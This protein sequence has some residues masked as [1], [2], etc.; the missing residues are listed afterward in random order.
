MEGLG[1][2]A[3]G[4]KFGCIEKYPTPFQF[5]PAADAMVNLPDIGAGMSQ[6]CP[7]L[8]DHRVVSTMNCKDRAI[9]K[10]IPTSPSGQGYAEAM[11]LG[12]IPSLIQKNKKIIGRAF[13]RIKPAGQV[14]TITTNLSPQDI[15]CGQILH[16]SEPR[17]LSI[18]EARRVQSIPDHEV[19]IGSLWEQWRLIGN[20]VDR[21]V[22]LA[23]GLSLRRAWEASQHK[24]RSDEGRLSN[25][26]VIEHTFPTTVKTKSVVRRTVCAVAIPMRCLSLGEKRSREEAQNG[27]SSDDDRVQVPVV[28]R[29]RTSMLKADLAVIAWDRVPEKMVKK[30]LEEY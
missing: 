13:R 4:E 29:A 15:R 26:K 9:I 18:Q 2:L 30:S 6:T 24:H 1:K 3:N 5:I 21:N 11:E 28:K 7:S 14:Q 25:Y 17:T 27:S 20:G 10:R 23:L 12:L 19:L 16:W 8:P 22:S